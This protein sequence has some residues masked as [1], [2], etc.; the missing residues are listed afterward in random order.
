MVSGTPLPI[1]F[2]LL[3]FQEA[4]LAEGRKGPLNK[5]AGRASSQLN[6]LLSGRWVLP[7]QSVCETLTGTLPKG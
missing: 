2:L 3:P 5:H 1:S 6:H 7:G 4:S